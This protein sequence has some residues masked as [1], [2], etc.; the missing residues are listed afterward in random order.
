M[1]KASQKNFW[2]NF[3]DSVWEK[4][5][6]LAKNFNSPVH[7]IDETQIFSMLVTYSDHCRKEKVAKG[8]KLYLNGQMQYE[9][10]VLQFLPV[11][12]DKSLT[13]YHQRMEKDFADYCLVCDELLQVSQAHF[14][15]LQEFADNLFNHVGF[16][17]RFVEMG[18][19]LGNYRKTPFGVHVD[20]CG[21]F[22]F[23]VLG[24][25]T[26]R[27]W[28][29][30]FAKKNPTLDRA[31]NYSKFIKNSETLKACTGDMTYWPSSAWHIAES[32]G[33]FSTTWSLGVWVDQTHQ[34]NLE[35][36]LKPLLTEKFGSAGL[37]TVTDF[38][39]ELPQIYLDSIS[40]LRKLTKNELHDVFLKDW[41]KLRS[42][43]GFKNLPVVLSQR[44][45]LLKDHIQLQPGQNIHWAKLKT[46][47]QMFYAFHGNIFDQNITTDV[48]KLIKD[49]NF[50]KKCLISDYLNK[51][52]DLKFIQALCNRGAFY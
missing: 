25:K 21:V 14:N 48:H 13:G 41:L 30:E 27:L 31:H 26:F 33:S 23:P 37:T 15:H 36:A 39:T 40:V 38:S 7:R 5:P 34:M 51:M 50:G 28:K 6:L 20:G 47:K 1:T 9:E 42:K 18:L 45:L 43:Q 10:D 49:L 19:Y 17:N 29:P 46:K 3:A 4:K 11:Q 32:D 52:I 22:S 16:P 35:K 8:F 24:K 2:K 12:N 44:K